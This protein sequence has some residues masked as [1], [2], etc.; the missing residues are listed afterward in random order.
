MH[1]EANLTLSFLETKLTPM[2]QAMPQLKTK[3]IL[4]LYFRTHHFPLLLMGDLQ[5]KK[6]SEN[7]SW[8]TRMGNG[9]PN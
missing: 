8:N 4:Q 9:K 1:K 3:S 5:I 2:F 7:S 6:N